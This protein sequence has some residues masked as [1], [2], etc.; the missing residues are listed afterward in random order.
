MLAQ[1]IVELEGGQASLVFD[2]HTR[3]GPLDTTYVVGTQGTLS[4]SGPDLGNQTVTLYTEAG[5]AVPELRG[6]WFNDGFHGAMGELLCSVEEGREPLNSARGNLKS[7]ELCFAAI[8]AARSGTAQHPGQIRSL[9][10]L[11]RG[12]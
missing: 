3:F 6:T 8:A 11:T 5:R 4:S 10:A 2:A 1:A 12:Q 9:K 7:L